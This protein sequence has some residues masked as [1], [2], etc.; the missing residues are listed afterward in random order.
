MALSVIEIKAIDDLVQ[1]F[2]TTNY[3]WH[4]S[5]SLFNSCAL[6][7][8]DSSFHQNYDEIYDII[9]C[10]VKN[11]FTTTQLQSYPAPTI[12]HYAENAMRNL[13]R[14]Y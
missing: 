12:G 3:S 7:I 6:A 14:R 2:D 9:K 10:K 8:S 1:S 4:K 5:S 11:R 13:K